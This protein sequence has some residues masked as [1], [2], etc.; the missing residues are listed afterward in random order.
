MNNKTIEDYEENNV[1]N[2]EAIIECYNGYIYTVI[3]NSIPYKEDIE[4]V[5]LTI[6]DYKD[7]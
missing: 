6:I 2:I 3:K 1:L 7:K 4:E 5:L